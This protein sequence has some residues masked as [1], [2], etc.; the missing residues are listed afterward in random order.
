MLVMEVVAH[1]QGGT[2][3]RFNKESLAMHTR[4]YNRFLV[5]LRR[6]IK[7]YCYSRIM[8]SSMMARNQSI[9]HHSF[10]TTNHDLLEGPT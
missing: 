4:K 8:I 10:T 2:W 5:F 9:F 6:D 7:S 3:I 1:M